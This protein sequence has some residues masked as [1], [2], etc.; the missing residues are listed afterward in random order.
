MVG[1]AKPFQPISI[2]GKLAYIIAGNA[3][4]MRENNQ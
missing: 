2:P 4:L 1:V 3:W